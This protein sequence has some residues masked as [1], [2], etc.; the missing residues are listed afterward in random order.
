MTQAMKPVLEVI[1][2]RDF[3]VCKRVQPLDSAVAQPGYRNHLS[4]LFIA[5]ENQVSNQTLK[6]TLKSIRMVSYIA[7]SNDH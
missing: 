3:S 1:I 7:A 5:L 2:F 6:Q 4:G